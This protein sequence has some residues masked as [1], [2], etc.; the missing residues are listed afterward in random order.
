MGRIKFSEVYVYA[1]AERDENFMKRF[2]VNQFITDDNIKNFTDLAV[3]IAELKKSMHGI[4]ITAVVN[5]LY[6][7]IP[8]D[9]ERDSNDDELLYL[10]QLD[11][12][13]FD[14]CVAE[15]VITIKESYSLEY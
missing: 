6:H 2:T 3:Y 9:E 13:E 1:G 10:A 11:D 7:A 12:N 14:N 15:E 8:E 4:S 5:N